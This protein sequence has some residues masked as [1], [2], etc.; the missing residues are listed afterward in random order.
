MTPY[1]VASIPTTP[2]EAIVAGSPAKIAHVT[3]REV[4]YYDG[5]KR[6]RLVFYTDKPSDPCLT[7][8]GG[9]HVRTHIMGKLQ[10]EKPDVR[11]DYFNLDLP[12]LPA[13]KATLV[14]HYSRSEDKVTDQIASGGLEVFEPDGYRAWRYAQYFNAALAVDSVTDG[15]LRGHLL[16]ALPDQGKSML[17]GAFTAKRCPPEK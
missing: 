8:P 6:Q 4:R 16:L 5:T 13:D 1:E 9:G 11:I 17:A 2:I 14:G 15:E 7:R 10:K 12:S 3:M